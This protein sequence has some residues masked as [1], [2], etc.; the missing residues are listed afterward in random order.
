MGAAGLEEVPNPSELFLA[1]R[2]ADAPGSCVV[3]AARGLAAD[4]DRAPG[5][6]RAGGLRHRAPHLPRHRRRARRAAPRGARPAQRRRPRRPRRLRE[7]DRRRAGRPRRRRISASRSRSRRAASISPLPPDVAACGEVGLGGE[8]R[9]VAR[10]DLRVR[11]AARLGFRRVLVPEGAAAA[12]GRSE[13]RARARRD[14]RRCGR[15]AARA[16]A[17]APSA[18][19]EPASARPWTT[20]KHA[21]S[22]SFSTFGGLSREPRRG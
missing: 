14:P 11:E 1:E 17:R 10:L 16:R 9:R 3:P 5:A 18:R 13:R 22:T 4:A 7:R 21:D 8:V 6:G 15:L 20:V 19:R 12:A 2:R